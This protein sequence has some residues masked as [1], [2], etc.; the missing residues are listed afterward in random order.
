MTEKQDDKAELFT[1]LY[2]QFEKACLD[3]GIL[4]IARLSSTPNSVYAHLD[5]VTV[6]D[7]EKK[8]ILSSL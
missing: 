3:Q 2:K 1:S 7:E 8:K 4:P 5:F 6:S